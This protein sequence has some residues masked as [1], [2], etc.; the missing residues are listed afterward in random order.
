MW[1]SLCICRIDCTEAQ[2]CHIGVMITVF[3]LGTSVWESTV[4]IVNIMIVILS[5]PLLLLCPHQLPW[6]GIPLK[7]ILAGGVIG[8]SIL[9]LGSAFYI[10][11]SKGVG[12]NG[13]TV[14]VSS[15][16]LLI[17]ISVL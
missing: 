14:A 4:M 11:F 17:I 3:I 15:L 9:N 13:A 5:I 8:S 2:F 12:K 6:F 10:I 1:V 16:L 7:I